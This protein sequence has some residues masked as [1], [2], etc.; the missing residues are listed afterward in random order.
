MIYLVLLVLV[1]KLVT[2]ILLFIVIRTVAIVGEQDS[3]V[4]SDLIAF[5]IFVI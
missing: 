2:I 1:I 4:L 5:S 3:S